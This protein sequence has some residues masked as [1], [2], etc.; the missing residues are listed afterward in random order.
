MLPEGFLHGRILCQERW[1]D[2]ALLVQSRQEL[3]LFRFEWQERAQES[4]AFL[5]ELSAPR[6][7]L[8][9]SRRQISPQHGDK[10]LPDIPGISRYFLD[11]DRSPI[12]PTRSPIDDKAQAQPFR[13]KADIS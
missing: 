5:D 11:L 12:S 6:F 13:V 3:Q 1:L 7:D 10:L 4:A 8:G 9:P 2:L